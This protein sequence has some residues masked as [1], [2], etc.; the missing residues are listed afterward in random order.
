[1]KNR[2]LRTFVVHASA[3]LVV[4]LTSRCLL[5][6]V[7]VTIREDRSTNEMA[8]TRAYVRICETMVVEPRSDTVLRE[9]S[10]T[11]RVVTG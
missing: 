2:R 9:D 5:T 4:T 10:D 3:T 8:T 7:V 6:G 11:R 1:M